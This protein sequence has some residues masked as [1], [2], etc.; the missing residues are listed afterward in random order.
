MPCAE[1]D[2]EAHVQPPVSGAV[3]L[4]LAK[5]EPHVYVHVVPVHPTLVAFVLLHTL[6]QPPQSDVDVRAVHVLPQRV[7]RHVHAPF[8]Q[9]GLGCAHVASFVH[10]P[11]ALHVRGVSPLHD[12]WPGAHEP[13]HVPVP[14]PLTQVSPVP[15]VV[16][17]TA[18]PQVPALVHEYAVLPWHSDCPG[19]Q[20]PVHAF[21]THVWSLHATAWPHVPPAVHVSIA[22]LP[23]H[24]VAPGVHEPVQVPLTHAELVQGTGVVPQV[25]PLHVTTPLLPR[26]SHSV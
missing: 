4:Q 7:S 8:W 25:P 15:C 23:E 12:V 20:S 10:V 21:V 3:V 16:Q 17:F 5:P 11:V 22:P 6:L 24:C 14:L 18:L 13:W 9:S 26:G 2:A 1:L 19:A